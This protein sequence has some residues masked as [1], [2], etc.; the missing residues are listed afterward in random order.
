MQ[1]QYTFT[2]TYRYEIPS[3]RI[4]SIMTEE[5]GFSFTTAQYD[6]KTETYLDKAR[7]VCS[8]T[9]EKLSL[10]AFKIKRG[11]VSFVTSDTYNNLGNLFPKFYLSGR[12]IDYKPRDRDRINKIFSFLKDLDGGKG[13]YLFL[14]FYWF[15]E[16]RFSM[17]ENRKYIN[18]LEIL[19]EIEPRD[20]FILQ[21]LVT[22]KD[23]HLFFN[24]NLAYSSNLNLLDSLNTLFLGKQLEELLN[25]EIGTILKLCKEYFKV[26]FKYNSW[27]ECDGIE[28][29]NQRLLSTNLNNNHFFRTQLAT[30]I[31]KVDYEELFHNV[32]DLLQEFNLPTTPSNFKF[33]LYLFS[34]DIP[35]S[36]YMLR[37][38]IVTE[39]LNQLPQTDF[40]Q[41]LSLA[42]K[43]VAIRAGLREVD[44]HYRTF[45]FKKL[46]YRMKKNVLDVRDFSSYF[47]PDSFTKSNLHLV[48]SLLYPE[49]PMSAL[50]YYIF[51]FMTS[52][53]YTRTFDEL[54]ATVIHTIDFG[55]TRGLDI[56]LNPDFAKI[57]K[58]NLEKFSAGEE[59]KEEIKALLQ[60]KFPHVTLNPSLQAYREDSLVF[61]LYQGDL[62][63]AQ[64][65]ALNII[66]Y[67]MVDSSKFL[68]PMF[69]TP[70][71]LNEESGALCVML[72]NKV[73]P[74]FFNM[75]VVADVLDRV[76]SLLPTFDNFTDLDSLSKSINCL[77]SVYLRTSEGSAKCLEDK[78]ERV[79][80]KIYEGLLPDEKDKQKLDPDLKLDLLVRK[81]KEEVL[82]E[83]DFTIVVPETKTDINWALTQLQVPFWQRPLGSIYNDSDFPYSFLYLVDKKDSDQVLAVVLL[84]SISASI[85]QIFAPYGA[86]PEI[87]LMLKLQKLAPLSLK[88]T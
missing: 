27:E 46:T 86:E 70:F 84:D 59:Y 13:I 10:V 41:V 63:K 64:E 79:L 43:K 33:I 26:P 44:Q 61:A 57:Y 87:D 24:P 52:T 38:A 67:W 32:L 16:K 49:L 1:D 7:I 78:N 30:A 74:G 11:T 65:I 81:I 9:P 73:L 3:V 6:S 72:I 77:K 53:T 83:E 66:Y 17:S 56:L 58:R 45:K 50:S 20:F 76:R 14:M 55:L 68:H 62:Q 2:S 75:E 39:D 51:L 42:D 22:N 80:T 25:E 88:Y 29:A 19:R 35:Y 36:V 47:K 8:I 28:A 40:S 5:G 37:H 31:G 15:K 60:Q 34:L 12:S 71:Q 69:G 21:K 48:M 18:F 82:Q 85:I 23:F 4:H 54:M